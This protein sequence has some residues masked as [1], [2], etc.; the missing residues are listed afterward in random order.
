MEPLLDTPA[1]W[2]ESG[3]VT[4]TVAEVLIGEAR[5]G[6]PAEIAAQYAGV[7]VRTF[8]DWLTSGR[9]V[10]SRLKE[11][12]DLELTDRER[13]LAQ[14]ATDVQSAHADWLR[15]ANEIMEAAARSRVRRVVKEKVTLVRDA[16]GVETGEEMVERTVT[17]TDEPI[18]LGP[19]QW[20]MGK[21]QPSFYGPLTRVEL[22]GADG[23]AV[24]LDVGAKLEAT[25]ARINEALM[26][27]P[28]EPESL[29]G[30]GTHDDEPVV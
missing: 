23:G 13:Q 28:E 22:T 27:E 26:L 14:F 1:A 24:E 19:L 25:L 4:Q 2:D 12:P 9:A 7:S 17:V 6:L 5:K 18:E 11:T 21:L 29:N 20:R 15:G 30:N 3:A 16:E 8:R 10:F